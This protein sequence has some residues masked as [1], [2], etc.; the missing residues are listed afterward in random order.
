MPSWLAGA[1]Q[2]G[3]GFI[4]R[5]R[6]RRRAADLRVRVECVE[7]SSRGVV[8][9][10]PWADHGHWRL[11]SWSATRAGSPIGIGLVADAQCLVRLEPLLA[12]NR[13]WWDRVD[14]A[15]LDSAPRVGLHIRFFIGGKVD[16]E[17]ETVAALLELLA[18]RP[19]VRAGLAD[20][21]RVQVLLRDLRARAMRSEPERYG[22]LRKKAEILTALRM[23]K[24]VHPLGGRPVWLE[25]LVPLTEACDRVGAYLA[26]SPYAK[27]VHIERNQIESV[28]EA[29][30]A[31][32]EPWPFEALFRP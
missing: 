25:E 24:L 11:G 15:V 26:R 22:V 3:D 30:Y 10:L 31:G 27:D 2:D 5:G 1:A 9:E 21:D 14:E 23:E 16:R 29:H 19:A 17:R 6:G 13:R 7:A 20:A 18:Q 32:V 12:V 4:V 8:V 28:V